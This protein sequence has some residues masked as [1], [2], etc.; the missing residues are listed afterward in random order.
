MA[1]AGAVA[2]G[3]VAAHP[4]LLHR[5]LVS[6]RMQRD[7]AAR[8]AKAAVLGDVVVVDPDTVVHGVGVVQAAVL[9]DES[10]VPDADTTTEGTGIGREAVV[11]DAQAFV[12]TVDDDAAAVTGADDGETVDTGVMLGEEIV[13][14]RIRV[15]VLASHKDADALLGREDHL[16]QSREAGE[17]EFLPGQLID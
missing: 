4:V 1:D 6:T 15:R 11:A 7:T 10:R 14:V 13:I 2:L 8:A 9:V 12:V 3:E 5:I 16:V 17:P